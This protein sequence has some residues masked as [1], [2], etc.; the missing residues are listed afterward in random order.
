VPIT[1]GTDVVFV[2]I[3]RHG[4]PPA[5]YRGDEGAD[6]SLPITEVDDVL[7]L[8]L[9]LV[10]QA[11]RDGVLPSPTAGKHDD[12]GRAGTGPRHRPRSA[13]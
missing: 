11:R 2:Q 13:R 4:R 10:A 5:G 9:R 12:E 6:F 7:V 1:G 3:E 8:L